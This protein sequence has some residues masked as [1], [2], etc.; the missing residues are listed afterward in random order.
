MR[1]LLICNGITVHTGAGVPGEHI[2][3]LNL[4]SEQ[5]YRVYE[6]VSPDY[7]I[8]NYG[9]FLFLYMTTCNPLKINQSFSGN[10]RLHLQGRRIRQARN[11][12]EAGGKQGL[13]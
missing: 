12:R 9:E 10:C 5:H 6:I 8:L 13:K 7:N 11:R 1:V 2:L 3:R 4:S